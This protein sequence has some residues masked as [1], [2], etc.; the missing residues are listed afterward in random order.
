MASSFVKTQLF[1]KRLLLERVSNPDIY[2]DFNSKFS[3]NL[4]YDLTDGD[5]DY[6]LQI[7]IHNEYLY[8]INIRLSDTLKDS[9]ILNKLLSKINTKK[10]FTYLNFYIKYLNDNL[11]FEFTNFILNINSSVTSFK[12]QMKYKNKDTEEK[13]TKIILKNLIKNE[14]LN[15]YNLYFV[16]C[17]FSSYENMTLLNEL[18]IK[19]KNKIKNIYLYN[20]IIYN[21]NFIADVSS[22]K[23][24]EISYFNLS[25]IKFF[26]KEKLN[27]SNNNISLDGIQIIS[28]YIKNQNCTLQK[29]NLNNNYIGDEGCTILS[30]G[31][32]KNKSLKT[33]NLSQNNIIFLGLINIANSLNSKSVDGIYNHT[34]KKLDFSRNSI[35]N[36]ALIDFCEILKNEPEERFIKINFQYNS[37][38]DLSIN[39]YGEF[40]QKY[41]N[42]TFLSLT[43]RISYDNQINFL[44]YC[45]RL[46]N[47][48]KI[49]IQN[50]KFFDEHSKLFNEILLNNKNIENIFI[51]YNSILYPESIKNISSGIEHNKN[52]TQI[53][54]TQCNIG[55]EGAIIL[56]NALFTNFNIN[57]IH[58]DENKI[59][60]EGA[61]AISEKL[62]GKISLKKLILSHN[63]IDSKGAFYIGKNLAE[64]QGIQN[65]FINSN[66]IGDEGCEFISKGL[67]KNISLVQLNINNNGITNK[68]I[69]S[70]AK[71]M[72]G[73]ENFMILSI[74]DNQ[75]QNVEDE[76]YKLLDWCKNVVISSNPLSKEG[77]IK[78]FQGTEKNKL[79]KDLRFKILD[80]DI[81]Y[82]FKTS[83]EN[84]KNFDLSYNN[85]MNISLLKHVLDLKNI[86]QLNIQSN[87][88]GDKN[89]SIIVKYIKDN[90]I[91]IKVLKMQSNCI[92]LEG[93]N[94]IAELLKSNKYLT[95]IN[96]AGNPLGY[97][98][99]KKICNAIESYPNEL[100]ELLLNFTQCNNYCSKD[101]YNMLI[102]NNKLKVISLIGNFLNNE[103]IDIILSSLRINN[104]LKEL[105]IGE[106]RNINA[107]GFENLPSYLRFNN[108]L[109]SLEIKSSRLNDDILRD[110]SKTLKNN[111]KIIILNLIDNKFG[112][113]A[114]M[115]F[116]LYIKKNDVINFL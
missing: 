46:T 51:Y 63:L 37:L 13:Y 107:K 111:K 58:L 71:V 9:H 25:Q 99:V 49:M 42:L 101:I 32:K 109:I 81:E 102:N 47:I 52:L 35:G 43:N 98:G 100:E 114:I 87:K 1:F 57:Q 82:N 8:N 90:N 28:E 16:D 89:I 56:S 72:I 50:F 45:K 113:L 6:L 55:D 27:L 70:I 34:I 94:G 59:G 110:I 95:S 23:T 92:G 31:I 38:T 88:I 108:N 3:I 19:N 60:E 7:I 2:K 10:Q 76:L 29:L 67:E 85:K 84:L 30:K 12:L 17:S 21:N 105:S 93:S 66:E 68:G 91:R 96:L 48:K 15:I 116:G 36:Q 83:N 112:Y 41:I 53:Y 73:K 65:L 26:H 4:N 78:L 77:I 54:L 18:L 40:I 5:L 86:S 104:S 115:K 11:F 79:F 106:N 24:F 64:A 33:L 22:L 80:E 97:K 103:G 74:A 20:S 39:Q 69:K 75:I 14:N 61:K 62:L 44:K